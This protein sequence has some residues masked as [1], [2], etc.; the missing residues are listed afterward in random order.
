MI[1]KTLGVK[2][3][4]PTFSN[5]GQEQI[6]NLAKATGLPEDLRLSLYDGRT[7]EFYPNKI[8]V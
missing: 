7:G 4:V 1:A 2:F 5:F 6:R 8:T 3:A